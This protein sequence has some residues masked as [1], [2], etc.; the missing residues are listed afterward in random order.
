MSQIIRFNN[1]YV[2]DDIRYNV[3]NSLQNYRFYMTKWVVI[4]F[5]SAYGIFFIF[6][7]NFLKK[8][9]LDAI[10]YYLILLI[11]LCYVIYQIDKI[12][13]RGNGVLDTTEIEEIN[14]Y[15]T[16]KDESIIKLLENYS[17]NNEILLNNNKKFSCR[18]CFDD[19]FIS[20]DVIK[21]RCSHIYCKECISKWCRIKN[22][23]P[24]CRKRLIKK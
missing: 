7:T 13:Y 2:E 22:E 24:L 4:G 3:Y 20:G 21:L 12:Y 19:K 17:E 23:C 5:S 14:I 15:D 11:L 16:M 1:P 9:I 10:F 6:Y 8:R 18:I